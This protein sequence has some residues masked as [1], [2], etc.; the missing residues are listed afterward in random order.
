MLRMTFKGFEKAEEQARKRI[1][2]AIRSKDFLEPVGD[3]VLANIKQDLRQGR[4]PN[5]RKQHNEPL[6]ASTIKQ[7]KKL[8]ESNSTSQF[9]KPNRPLVFSGTLINSLAYTISTSKPFIFFKAL[10]T[11]LPYVGKSGKRIGKPISN[12]RLL[13][14]HHTGEGQKQRS[15]IGISEQGSKSI[16]AIARKAIAK[17]LSRK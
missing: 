11:H 5:T 7:R 2:E 3:K 6:A 13:E 4:D 17:L 15:M 12:Q 16:L 14:I 10:G 8:A 1:Q 9:Y